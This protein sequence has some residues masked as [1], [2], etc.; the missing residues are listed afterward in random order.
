[1]QADMVLGNKR[2]RCGSAGVRKKETLGL[3][4]A[5]EA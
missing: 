4:W 1:M 5:F 3:A 2:S